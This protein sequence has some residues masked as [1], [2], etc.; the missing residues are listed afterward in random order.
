MGIISSTIPSLISYWQ[1]KSKHA[2]DLAILNLQIEAARNGLEISRQIADIKATVDEGNNLR[3]TDV[4][5]DGGEFINALRA[6]VRPVITYTLFGLFVGIKFFVAAIILMTGDLTVSN[7]KLA[8][9]AIL[10]DNTMAITS[11]VIGYYFGAR[12]LEKFQT[13]SAKTDITPQNNLNKFIN[14]K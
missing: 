8:F 5:L 1:Q 13:T 6:S 12:A 2:Y 4:E 7:M 9:D 14:I 11:T 10:D 3:S